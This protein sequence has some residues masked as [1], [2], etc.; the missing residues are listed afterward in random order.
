MGQI[1]K[2]QA[3][4]GWYQEN[5]IEPAMVEIELKFT[6]YLCYNDPDKKSKYEYEI[7]WIFQ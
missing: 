1:N 7:L 4:N 6:Q 2:E 3:A 5:D